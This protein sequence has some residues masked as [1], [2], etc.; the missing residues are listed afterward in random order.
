MSRIVQ[1]EVPAQA[2]NALAAAG[3][4]PV[5]A[6]VFAARGITEARELDLVLADLPSWQELKG[7][8]AAAARLAQA[9]EAKE[10]L[11]IVA[12]Y[13]A[14]GATACALGVLALRA[15]GAEVD[16]LVPN[17][18]EFGYGLTPEIVAL[19]ATREPALIVTVDN[20]IA[21]VE[22]VTEAAAR[23][24]EVL[25][26]DHHLPGD[27]LPEPAIIV[28][29][30]QP[31]CAF[32]S[33]N[34]A[35]VGVMFYVL[36]ALR[37][38]LRERGWFANRAEPKLADYL[39]LVALGTI[40][41]VVKLDHLNRIL[42][43]HGLLRLRAGRA[44][45]G[46][47]M[48][49]A[50]AGRDASRLCGFDLGFVLGPR[51]NAAGRLADM[52]LGIRCLLAEDE[53]RALPLAMEL[54][55]LNRERK[56]LEADIHDEALSELEDQNLAE[57][58]S[59]VLFRP[60]WHQGVVGIVASRL[61]DRYHRPAI[62]F[63]AAGDGSLKGSGRSIRALHLRDALDRVAKLDPALIQ[64]FGGHAAAAGL[65]LPASGLARFAL[66]FEQAVREALLPAD[67]AR[68]VETDGSLAP[69]ELTLELAELLAKPL[70]GQAFAA[71]VFAD[72]FRVLRQ[73]VVAEKHLRLVL[74][75]EGKVFE[76]MLFRH[77]E[78]LPE[79]ILAVY[80]PE[81]NEYQGHVRL[82]LILEH[83]QAA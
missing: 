43:Q 75:R 29:P 69:R 35:G 40:A 33:K 23:G 42:V 46:L 4:H 45:P 58:Y 18:F 67:L 39:D 53:D 52:S 11:L 56:G 61:K 63:A 32:P 21:S 49:L 25:I 54:D 83:W 44:R 1:R 65:T 26:T 19:A 51:L 55:R 7:I 3:L 60:E 80:R 34:L 28:N 22:G 10:R 9:I 27:R 74:A 77:A 73:N 36:L 72:E 5:L 30:N 78:A 57:R 37:A 68:V 16:Y 64:R 6:R 12:D 59:L 31:G 48:L 81:R 20:G 13:D 66:L 70:W 14:D 24:I 79:R 15:M 2:K 71:P 41:D 17:R 62:V 76:A 8:S 38:H 82:Q 47:S 50:A